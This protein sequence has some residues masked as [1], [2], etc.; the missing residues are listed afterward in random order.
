MRSPDG[1][2]TYMSPLV[3]DIDN[4]GVLDIIFGT[5]GETFGG[6]LWRI[7]L[8]DL[9]SGDSTKAIALV[10]GKKKGFMA[11]PS[12]A[13]LNNDSVLDIITCSYDGHT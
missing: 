13:D 3:N 1:E 8:P 11:P 6:K 4:D 12:L 9:L 2:E 5:G 7:T 10:S